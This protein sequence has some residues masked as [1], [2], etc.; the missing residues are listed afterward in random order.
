[1]LNKEKTILSLCSGTGAWERPY[2]EAGYNVI[3]VTLPDND[4][5]RYIPPEN[6]YGILAAPPCT[7]FSFARTRAETPRD[8]KEGMYCVSGCM[9]IIWECRYRNKLAFWALENPTG[10]LRQFLGKPPFTFHPYD[11]GD[12]YTKKT[13][14]WGYFNL[15][16]NSPVDLNQTEM[17][18]AYTNSRKLP[19]ISDITGSSQAD[20]RALTPPGFARAFYEAN[21]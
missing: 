20:K 18:L 10:Y 13:D 8:L 3:P 6:V 7:M 1:M 2:V 9:K 16:K 21:Q 12:R 17:Q 4:V 11:F 5:N 14:L 15:P 19:S